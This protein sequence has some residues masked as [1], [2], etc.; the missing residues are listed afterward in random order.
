MLAYPYAATLYLA[1]VGRR[2]NHLAALC[3]FRNGKKKAD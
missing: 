3:W 1:S 2:E